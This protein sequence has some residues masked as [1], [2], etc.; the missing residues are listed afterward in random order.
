M[1]VRID[2]D[3]CIGCGACADVCPTGSLTI[4]GNGVCECNEDTCAGCGAC[5]G[6]C[7]CDAI[8]L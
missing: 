6:T 5:V 1:A 2:C 7:P 4:N 8:S 3:K